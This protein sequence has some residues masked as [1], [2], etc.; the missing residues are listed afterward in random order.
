MA[1]VTPDEAGVIGSSGSRKRDGTTRKFSIDFERLTSVDSSVRKSENA[2]L[3][4]PGTAWESGSVGGD[5]GSL[6]LGEAGLSRFMIF[7]SQF[8]RSFGG[9]LLPSS[10]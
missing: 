5:T 4:I 1:T 6:F 7:F 2:R 8:M 10:S 3:Q 9:H